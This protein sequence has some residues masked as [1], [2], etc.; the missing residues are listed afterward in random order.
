MKIVETMIYH[1]LRETHA[2][3]LADMFHT[4]GVA[5]GLERGYISEQRMHIALEKC[6]RCQKSDACKSWL[7]EAEQ[8]SPPPYFCESRDMILRLANRRPS[9]ELK[10]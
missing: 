9:R 8:G 2:Q 6:I 1:Q 10:I 3:R 4:T 7:E 5:A